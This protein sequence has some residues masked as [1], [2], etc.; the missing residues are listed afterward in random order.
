VRLWLRSLDTLESHPLAGTE[1]TVTFFWSPDSR[2]VVFQ[3]AGKL[4]KI[5]LSGGPP[6]TVC[7]VSGVVLGGTWSA[8]GVILFGSNTGPIL[9]VPSGGGVAS[10]VTI[11]DPSSGGVAHSDPIF[12]ADGRRC[13]SGSSNRLLVSMPVP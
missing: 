1:G 3:S 6:Q 9:R 4:K 7:D 5:D 2:F 12:L 13:A 11:L 8:N 10:P